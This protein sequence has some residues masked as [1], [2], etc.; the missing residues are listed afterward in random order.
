MEPRKAVFGIAVAMLLAFAA[1]PAHAGP[2]FKGALCQTKANVKFSKTGVD[3]SECEVSSD[4]TSTVGPNGL[5]PALAKASGDSDAGADILTGGR[6][7]AYATDHSES[8]ASSDTN[9]HATSHADGA[10]SFAEAVSDGGARSLA[11][12]SGGGNG[13]SAAFGE[14]GGTLIGFCTAHG[15]AIGANS[16]AFAQCEAAGHACA[17]ATG[18]GTALAFDDKPPTCTPN[19]GTANV[20]SSGGNCGGPCVLVP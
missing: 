15:T 5:L 19:G 13:Q 18:G 17:K 1:V 2:K 20:R 6:A 7:H 8:F 10:K 4:G 12:A 14:T 16:T 9:G 11:N 3:M